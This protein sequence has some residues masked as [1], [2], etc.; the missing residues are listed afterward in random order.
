IL[1]IACLNYMNLATA[2][3]V[4]RSREVGL[5][6]VVGANRLNLLIQFLGESVLVSFMSFFLSLGLV[7]LLLSPF[8]RLMDRELTA[9]AITA[10]ATLTMMLALTLG[11]GLISGAYPSFFLSAFH[12]A[13]I[14]R[15]INSKGRNRSQQLR[16]TLVVLQFIISISLIGGTL[17]M[18]RQLSYIHNKDLGFT[19]DY[20]FTAYIRDPEIRKNY[21]TVKNELLALPGVMDVTASAQL[22]TTI[23]SNSSANWEGKEEGQ[24]I[25][26][27]KMQVDYNTLDFYEINLLEGRQFSRDMTTDKT[28]AYILNRSAVNALGWENALGK[29]FSFNRDLPGRVIGVVEDFHFFPLKLQIEPMAVML[30]NSDSEY[31]GMQY[32]SIRILSKNIRQTVEQ[33]QGTI[34]TFSPVFPSVY[35]FFDERVDNMYKSERRLAESFNLFTLIAI[36]IACMGLFGLASFS[37]EQRAREISIRKVLGATASTISILLVQS[38]LKWVLIAN[39][40]AAPVV[41][42]SMS[43]W[44]TQFAYRTNLGVDIFVASALLSLMIALLTIGM[45]TVKAAAAQPAE[46]LRQET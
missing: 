32:F 3:S 31:Q 1:L 41:Y 14:F 28:S 19:K 34:D 27:Y 25:H 15:G 29:G 36:G 46:V 5:R 38:F 21:Q 20:I 22:P 11:V 16:N 40:I 7:F 30:I 10:P 39:V 4:G 35:G 9:A 17:V 24:N 12:P 13:S 8:N 45:Q 42:F 26:V 44:L 18:Q 23:R 6:K 2:R 37:A 43:R 33:I